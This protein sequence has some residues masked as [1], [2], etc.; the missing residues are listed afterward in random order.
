MSKPKNASAF[1]AP[2]YVYRRAG[3]PVTLTIPDE[4]RLVV[5]SMGAKPSVV[6]PDVMPMGRYELAPEPLPGGD[7]PIGLQV[8]SVQQADIVSRL[9]ADAV[10]QILS[11]ATRIDRAE[12]A[13]GGAA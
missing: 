4:H 7:W 2:F 12:L 8:L 9:S 5:F 10:S 13:K 6:P 11:E 1:K 3:A